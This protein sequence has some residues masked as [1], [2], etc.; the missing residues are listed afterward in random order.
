M[1]DRQA[2]TNGGV[3]QPVTPG[4]FERVVDLAIVVAA[5][6]SGQF[7]GADNVKTVAG[8][9]EILVSQLRAGSDI[10]HHQIIIRVRAHP[11]EQ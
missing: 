11:Q 2:G 5:A 4:F 6:C 8:E 7:V 3:I 9:I 1:V 10:Q